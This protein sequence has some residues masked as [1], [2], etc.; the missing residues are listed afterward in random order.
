MEKIIFNIFLNSYI[1]ISN[2]Y[3]IFIYM[4][5][6]QYVIPTL[7]YVSYMLIDLYTILRHNWNIKN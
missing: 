3:L 7:L 5:I 6:V 4:Y 2:A 1:G